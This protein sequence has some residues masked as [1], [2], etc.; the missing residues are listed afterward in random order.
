MHGG[1]AQVAVVHHLFIILLE[2]L[3]AFVIQFEFFPFSR[4]IRM[5]TLEF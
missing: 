5:F 3:Q 2:F 4:E 1:V